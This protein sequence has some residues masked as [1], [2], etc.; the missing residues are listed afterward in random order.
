MPTPPLAFFPVDAPGPPMPDTEELNHMFR[1]LM[2]RCP[3][4]HMVAALHSPRR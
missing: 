1:Q 3:T 2:V 4:A